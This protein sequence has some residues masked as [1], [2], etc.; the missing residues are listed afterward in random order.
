[1]TMHLDRKKYYFIMI[2]NAKAIY[3]LE[4]L[5]IKDKKWDWSLFMDRM[6]MRSVKNILAIKS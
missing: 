4:N 6:S 5:R 3:L 1:M 2:Y